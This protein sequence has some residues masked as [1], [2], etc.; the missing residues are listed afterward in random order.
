MLWPP[1]LT[2]FVKLSSLNF[3]T[4]AP[5]V[6]YFTPASLILTQSAKLSTLRFLD[7]ARH[8]KLASLIFSQSVSATY[9]SSLQLLVNSF[10]EMSV[11]FWFDAILILRSCLAALRNRNAPSV[12]CGEFIMVISVSWSSDEQHFKVI[13]YVLFNKKSTSMCIAKQNLLLLNGDR[14]NWETS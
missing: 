8:F 12:K 13:N 5:S 3:P 1:I 14:S 2:Q 10:M 9:L 7:A 6:R 11:R 4:Q